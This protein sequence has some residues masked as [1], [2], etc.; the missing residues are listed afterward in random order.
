[1][2]K[3]AT[4]RQQCELGVFRVP[5]IVMCAHS[6]DSEVFVVAGE[7]GKSYEIGSVAS[8]KSVIEQKYYMDYNAS[9]VQIELF[10]F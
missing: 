3:W 4:N 8:D 7:M 5:D 2:Y 1:M 6:L 10:G 9:R